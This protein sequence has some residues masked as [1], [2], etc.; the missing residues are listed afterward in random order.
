[1]TI[2]EARDG[3][4]A[5]RRFAGQVGA[6]PPERVQARLDGADGVARLCSVEAAIADL[7]PR[8]TAKELVWLTRSGAGDGALLHLQAFAPDGGVIAAASFRL[9]P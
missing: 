7:W 1:M 3:E 2:K 5:V 9:T 6:T 8:A 4:D